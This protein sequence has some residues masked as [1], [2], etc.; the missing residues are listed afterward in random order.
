MSKT[1]HSHKQKISII[2]PVYNSGDYLAKALDSIIN[3][4]YKNWKLICV[5]DGSTDNSNEILRNYSKSDD[6][7]KVVTFKKNK[8]LT[9][10]L[11]KA[12]TLADGNY[13]ARMD[14]DDISLPERL[15]KQVKFLDQHPNVIAVGTQCEL[16]DESGKVFGHKMFPTESKKL[17]NMMF[18][19]M[20]MQHPTIMVRG[21]VYRRERYEDQPTAE[22]VS[23]Y[24]RLLRHGN[25]ANLDEVLFQYRI[26]Q[27]SNSL[28]NI[29][30]TFLIT[31]KT[32]LRAVSEWGYK[33]S[34]Y[35][36]MLNVFQLLVVTVLPPFVVLAIYELARF[37]K[38]SGQKN[39]RVA[40]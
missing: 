4:T 23:L 30:R 25:L 5:D 13:I 15:E 27:N 21:D 37:S 14:S 24:F 39:G 29:K 28:K 8:G 19:I 31:F 10:A 33:P 34:V 11:N 18:Q 9:F 35:S 16:I 7:I 17:Y 26:R 1:N 36:I 6:R 3:Q 12:L 38:S 40:S 22:D 2:M 32:R 20:P